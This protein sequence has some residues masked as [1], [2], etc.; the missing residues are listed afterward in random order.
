[1]ANCSSTI[2]DSDGA[3]FT[4]VEAPAEVP[5]TEVL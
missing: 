3:S 2:L 1:V 5:R 4:L